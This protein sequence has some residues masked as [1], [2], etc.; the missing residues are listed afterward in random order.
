MPQLVKGGKYIF[1][2]SKIGGNGA[3]A[4]PPEACEEY[5]FIDG[6][7]VV[8][9]NGSRTSGGFI[10]TK[11]DIIK[12]SK[13]GPMFMNVPGLVE[14]R[15]PENEIIK[16]RGRLFCWSTVIPGGCIR[17]PEAILDAYRI[18]RG[19]LLATGRGSHLGLAFIARG[20]VHNEALKHPE[21][22]NIRGGLKK[23][24]IIHRMPL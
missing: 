9:F 4:I 19:G 17:L 20:M 8:L 6:D 15:I 24:A 14:Y 7:R 12:K 16:Y 5:G 23:S 21:T 18:K 3:I 2:L 1:G 10:V 11:F 13:P 22:G